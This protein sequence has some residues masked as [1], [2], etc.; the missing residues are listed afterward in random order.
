MSGNTGVELA[1]I[2]IG[3]SAAVALHIYHAIFVF[4]W[5]KKH[6]LNHHIWFVISLVWSVW[7]WYFLL[8]FNPHL[9]CG[10]R[11]PIKS[12]EVTGSNVA[13]T[14]NQSKF[15]DLKVSLEQPASN[16]FGR[17]LPRPFPAEPL[18]IPDPYGKPLP[19]TQLC[20]NHIPNPYGKPF[21]N[22]SVC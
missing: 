9:F 19:F 17:P 3:A 21:S 2:A 11:L 13:T 22:H 8:L 14:S 7:V 18:A 6:E 15:N 10:N 1:L 20:Q 5:A 4:K 16:P 12:Q